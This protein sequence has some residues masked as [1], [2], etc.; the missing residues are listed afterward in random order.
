MKKYQYSQYLPEMGS[1][2]T[3]Y[4]RTPK[5]I[6]YFR[7]SCQHGLVFDVAWPWCQVREEDTGQRYLINREYDKSNTK[8]ATVLKEILTIDRDDELIFEKPEESYA[9][10]IFHEM[11]EERG[12]IHL[13]PLFDLGGASFSL[14]IRPQHLIWKDLNGNVDLELKAL[15]PALVFYIP[16]Q[17]DRIFDVL[18]QT[19]PYW[20]KGTLN[21]KAV[22]G[23]GGIDTVWGPPGCN[24]ISMKVNRFLEKLY[25]YWCNVYEDGSKEWGFVLKGLDQLECC[26]YN[27]N[28]QAR[29]T[30]QNQ[31]EIATFPDGSLSGATLKMDALSFQFTVESRVATA[32]SVKWQGASGT[33]KVMLDPNH[34]SGCV[35]NLNEKRKPVKCFA[36]SEHHPGR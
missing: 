32:P 29:I 15:G 25:I 21:G 27:R 8:R 11:D 24:W 12:V 9:G 4:L 20:V 28:G 5:L 14:D 23:M 1:M 18:Y 7:T 17:F 6:E 13:E 2:A 22:S 30:K 31:I 26:C 34:N 19:E 36:I 10:Y 16:G 35:I 3:T 33:N